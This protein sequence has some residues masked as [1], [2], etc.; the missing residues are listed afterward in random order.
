[1][2]LPIMFLACCESADAAA[3]LS[4]RGLISESNVPSFRLDRELSVKRFAESPHCLTP[5]AARLHTFLVQIQLEEH[6]FFSH[7]FSEAFS[8]APFS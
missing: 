8:A 7:F 4:M 6:F 3:S 5:F 2:L 1:M